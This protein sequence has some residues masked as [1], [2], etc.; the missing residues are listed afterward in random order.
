MKII[1]FRARIEHRQAVTRFGIRNDNNL[2]TTG[3]K[4]HTLSLNT[5]STHKIGL[6]RGINRSDTRVLFQDAHSNRVGLGRQLNIG[7]KGWDL[8]SGA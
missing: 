1:Q 6:S 2:L 8:R 4:I 5:L 3:G 7:S